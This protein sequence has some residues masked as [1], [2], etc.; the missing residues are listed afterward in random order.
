VTAPE[1]SADVLVRPA[2]TDDARAAVR[3]LLAS[4][5]AAERSG[6][7]PV[8]SHDD[9]EVESWF[10]ERVMATREVWVAEQDGTC[11]GVLVLDEAWLDHLYVLPAWTG[12]GI[13]S[14]LLATA[15]ALRPAG[16]DL[17]VFQTN[18]AAQGFYEQHGLEVVERTDGSGNGEQA[19][20][21]RYRAG[22]VPSPS[23]GPGRHAG[24]A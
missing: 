16:F 10:C 22:R 7:I 23:V 20:D 13:G 17:W 8:D 21:I 4:R 24:S 5:R 18:T 9:T 11:V 1:P 14:L 12:R 3:T 6:A 19:P 15:R 2:T